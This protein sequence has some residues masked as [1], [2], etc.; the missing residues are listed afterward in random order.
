MKLRAWVGVFFLGSTIVFAQ[1]KPPS[2][3][4]DQSASGQQ[5]PIPRIQVPQREYD[6]GR[7]IDGEIATATFQIKNVGDA[8]LILHDVRAS[9]GC[10]IPKKLTEA[11]KKLDPGETLDLTA[12]FNSKGRIGKQRKTVTVISNDPTE[13]RIALIINAEVVTLMQVLVDGR[14]VRNIAAGRIRP[15]ETVPKVIAIL[16]TE[17]HQKLEITSI[18]VKSETVT[19]ELKPLTRDSRQGFRLNL[20]VVP[21]AAPGAISVPIKII[22]K[23]GGRVTEIK[24]RANLDVVGELAYTPIQVR[25]TAPLVIGNR[26]MP[27]R[28]RSETGRPFRVLHADA[29]PNIDIEVS[30][31]RAG[32][33]YVI[34]MTISKKA[35]IGPFGNYLTILTDSVV[36]PVIRIPV[37]GFVRPHVQA[38]PDHVFL[39]PTQQQN[40]ASRIVKLETA[41]RV[42]FE[43]QSIDV[44]SPAIQAEITEFPGRPARGVQYINVH[45]AT[46]APP[47]T[48]TADVVIHTNVADQPD[49]VIPVRAE[50]S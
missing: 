41:S 3:G 29:G 7:I 38:T 28:L 24:L 17:P 4:E 40:G 25:Q 16:P 27:V 23:I 13:P 37:Y 48:H 22:G 39:H 46:D 44:P 34:Q 5:A 9:C 30:K 31:E 47:G 18:N 36:Q 26:L 8:P 33:A 45:V 32:K 19:Y 43:I 50:I 49:I 2:P 1:S 6:M 20:S 10:T 42:P 35:S 14:E 12:Q 11:E 21:D 15:G